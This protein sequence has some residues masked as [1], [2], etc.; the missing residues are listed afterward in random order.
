MDRTIVIVDDNSAHL[1][2]LFEFLNKERVGTV[3]CFTDPAKA[4]AFAKTTRI[5]VL[6]TDYSMPE[7]NGIELIDALPGIPAMF[8]ISCSLPENEQLR[9]ECAKRGVFALD[10]ISLLTAL[11]E[12]PRR[13]GHGT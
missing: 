1:G 3:H 11:A 7:M 10:K 2:I 6:I 13:T 12:K 9:K 4:Q 8:L 5:D